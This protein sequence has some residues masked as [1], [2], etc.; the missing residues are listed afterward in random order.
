M[1]TSPDNAKLKHLRQLLSQKKARDIAQEFVLENENFIKDTL[2]KH[3][4]KI[5]S[6]YYSYNAPESILDAAL[7]H[8]IP[9]FDVAPD[10]FQKTHTI[11]TS[12]GVLA[13][14]KK[15]SPEFPKTISKAVFLDQ[16]N[17]PQNLGAIIR[18]AAAFN[19]DAVFLSPQS[20]DPFHPESIRAMA[21]HCFNIPIIPTKLETLTT[22]HPNL[23]LYYLSEKAKTSLFDIQFAPQTL[24]VFGSETGF[25]NHTLNSNNTKIPLRIPISAQV[26]SLN[27]AVA[28]GITFAQLSKKGL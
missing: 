8:H 21:G 24:V 12:C 16:I 19:L 3:P 26:D 22:Q 1:I 20:C 15:P 6:L 2:K 18:S 5:D 25:S 17:K 4:D 23:A 28:A 7:H 11:K 13:I 14:V 10:L 9:C 27:V